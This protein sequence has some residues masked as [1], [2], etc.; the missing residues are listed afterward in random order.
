MDQNAPT[1][2]QDEMQRLEIALR[3]LSVLYGQFFA[4]ALDRQPY[5]AKKEVDRIIDRVNRSNERRSYAERFHFN[6]IVSRYQ[7][8]MERWNKTM[9]LKEMGDE[10]NGES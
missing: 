9:R 3:R 10:E 1:T 5:E 7:T 4:G 6:T 2:F 8:H